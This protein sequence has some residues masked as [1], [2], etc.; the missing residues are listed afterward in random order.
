MYFCEYPYT[1]KIQ[2]L[3]SVLFPNFKRKMLLYSIWKNYCIT[4]VNNKRVNLVIKINVKSLIVVATEVWVSWGSI[5][6]YIWLAFCHISNFYAF[7][8]LCRT[9][10]DYENYYKQ[11][12]ASLQIACSIFACAIGKIVNL[13]VANLF[14]S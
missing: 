2:L 9:Y 1:L 3:I 12:V 5:L 10:W 8:L 14:I 13:H 4:F 6:D 7:V 11:H